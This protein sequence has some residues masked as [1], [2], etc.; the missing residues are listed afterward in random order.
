MTSP[1]KY[2]AMEVFYIHLSKRF[3]GRFLVTG[4]FA[5]QAWLGAT[6]RPINDLDLL[7]TYPF[8]AERLK[9]DIR[10]SVS[11]LK[12][13]HGIVWVKDSLTQTTIFE[14][15]DVPGV[16]S[17]IAFTFDE[18]RHSLQID[19]AKQDP[20]TQSPV[21]VFIPSHLTGVLEI[22]TVPAETAAAWKLHGLFEHLDGRWLSKSLIDLY[23]FIKS[24]SLSDGEFR[25]AVFMAF[26]SRLEPIVCLNRL[27]N[28]NFGGTKS[29]KLKW[30]TEIDARGID[31]KME[32]A[33]EVVRTYIKPLFSLSHAF[34]ITSNAELIEHRVRLLHELKNKAADKKLGTLRSRL[35]VLKH[36]AYS[37]IGHLP[38]S[39]TGTA[40]RHIHE[41][42]A[43]RLLEAC[44]DDCE[45]IIQEKLDGSCVAV[46]R[47]GREI[48]PLGREGDITYGSRNSSRRMWADWVKIHKDLFLDVLRDGE[49]LCG[50]WMAM[51][52]TV[53]YDEVTFPFFAFDLFGADKKPKGYDD[54]LERLAGSNIPTP[55]LLHRGEALGIEAAMEHLKVKGAKTQ[56]GGEGA[57]WRMERQGIPK[58]KAKYVRPD[59]EAGLFLEETTGDIS[60][61]NWHLDR[62]SARYAENSRLAKLI[63]KKGNVRVV[64]FDDAPHKRHVDKVIHVN[65]I[66]TNQAIFEGMISGVVAADGLNAAFVLADMVLNSKFD[67]QVHAILIDG[68]TFAFNTVDLPALYRMTQIPVIAVMRHEPNLKRIFKVIEK[69]C[70]DTDAYKKIYENAGTIFKHDK[71]FYQCYGLSETQAHYILEQS[72][73]TGHVPESLRIAHLIG[74]SIKTGQSSR[75]A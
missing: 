25:I 66:I 36:K 58:L 39:R 52:H 23:R 32:D 10:D 47:R 75:G 28:D 2:I 4:S 15:S 60:Q 29:S 48:L 74:S 16:R 69:Y 19:T 8:K 40:D 45:V 11:D 17:V 73:V 49:W 56:D 27:I 13:T 12:D 5:N 30:Q 70:D 55:A 71:F 26:H 24:G 68:I 59:F 9:S 37:G 63:H 34:E 57:I 31:L 21:T 54:L 1:A 44:P 51:V 14:D 7:E 42:E 35:R 67:D 20:L 72:T 33:L 64:G 62:K 3:P 43:A 18:E 46:Y 38:G 50:E 6:R 65:G 41:R 61:W 22:K 53:R